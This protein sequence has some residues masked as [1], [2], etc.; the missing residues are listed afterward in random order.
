MA[1]VATACPGCGIVLPAIDRAAHR[2]VTSS[3]ACWEGYGRL[4]AAQYASPE[5]MAFHQVVVDAYAAQHP[6]GDDPRAI[7][8]VAIHLMTMALFLEDG[9]NPAL[10]T[11]LHHRMVQRPVFHRLLRPEIVPSQRVTWARV[12]LAGPPSVARARAYDWARAVWA[13]WE[14]HQA[15]VRGWLAASEGAAAS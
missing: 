13:E 4:L 2:Y 15:T 10:G 1:T 12:P 9:V 14:P 8:S 5:R 3:P 6:G 7:R 11:S